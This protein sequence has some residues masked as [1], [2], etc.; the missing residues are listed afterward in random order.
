MDVG[1]LYF[2]ETEK[3][4]SHGTNLVFYVILWHSITY[5]ESVWF[6]VNEEELI[7]S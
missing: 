4:F 6:F 5:G 1:W 3:W 7:N 2:Y